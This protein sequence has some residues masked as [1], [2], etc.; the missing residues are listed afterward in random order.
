MY[1]LKELICCLVRHHLCLTLCDPVDLPQ[2]RKLRLREFKE[3]RHLIQTEQK[4]WG[5]I[6]KPPLSLP[7][8]TTL[9]SRETK[10]Q[11]W[12]HVT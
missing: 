6:R 3:L 10:S 5:L 1:A 12:C 9:Q 4:E 2:V 11:K 7:L 8:E